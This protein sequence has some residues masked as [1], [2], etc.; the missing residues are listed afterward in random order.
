MSTPPYQIAR[1]RP[2][3]RSAIQ[4]PGS[5]ARYTRRRVD[6]D[7]RRRRVA[8]EAEPAVRQRGGHEQDEERADPVVREPLPHLGEEQRREAAR[9]TEEA[10]A[11]RRGGG[12]LSTV[13]AASCARFG[14]TLTSLGASADCVRGREVGA[15]DGIRTAAVVIAASGRCRSG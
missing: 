3:Q 11:I 7:D 10:P 1:R 15:I 6:A 14:G 4:P 2:S 9:M 13:T 8:V 12:G 5:D